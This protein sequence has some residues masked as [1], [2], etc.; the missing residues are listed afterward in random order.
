MRSYKHSSA[1]INKNMDDD[2][3]AIMLHPR[4]YTYLQT[5]A[6]YGNRVLARLPVSA[7]DST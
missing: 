4:F 5:I 2:S 3:I 7:V 1:A 6:H